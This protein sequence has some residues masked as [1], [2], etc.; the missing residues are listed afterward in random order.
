[1]L[2]ERDNDRNHEA[3]EQAEMSASC[4]KI[5]LPETVEAEEIDEEKSTKLRGRAIVQN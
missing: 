3:S 4:A 2:D 1:L 5:L